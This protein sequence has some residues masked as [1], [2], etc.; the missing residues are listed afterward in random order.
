VD[1][2]FFLLFSTVTPILSKFHQKSHQNIK[3]VTA[4]RKKILKLSKTS[5]KWKKIKANLVQ[6]LKVSYKEQK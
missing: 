1:F 4:N 2:D 5:E 3:K 6:K